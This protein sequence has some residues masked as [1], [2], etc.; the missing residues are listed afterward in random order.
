MSL[1]A[2][3]R[4]L[5]FRRAF[6]RWRETY[7][8]SQQDIHNWGQQAGVPLHNSQIA[9]LERED[10]DFDPKVEFYFSLEAFNKAIKTESKNGF[11]YITKQLTR[12]RLQKAEP[13]MTHDGRVA[14]LGDFFLMFA[15]RQEVADTYKIKK[16]ELTLEFLK[17]Y[18]DLIEKAFEDVARENVFSKKECWNALANTKPM[19]LVEEPEIAEAARDA[20]RGELKPTVENAKYIMAKYQRCPLY[21]GLQAISETPLSKELTEAHKM[22]VAM[23]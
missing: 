22:L 4:S 14:E 11:K 1:T 13:F 16:L 6:K 20:C 5:S 10:R 17:K 19:Q 23:T 7:E 12:E 21:L 18:F 15:G 9:Y 3:E 2:L 8:L